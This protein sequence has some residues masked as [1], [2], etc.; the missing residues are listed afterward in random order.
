M[1]SELYTDLPPAI[2]DTL[3]AMM[4]NR[5]VQLNVRDFYAVPTTGR[6]I[7][8]SHL[9]IGSV[10][11]IRDVVFTFVHDKSCILTEV[12]TQQTVLLWRRNVLLDFVRDGDK[13]TLRDKFDFLTYEMT[14]LTETRTGA[15][16]VS[17]TFR[18][19]E[20]RYRDARKYISTRMCELARAWGVSGGV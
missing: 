6:D 11:S 3:S 20:D 16:V 10:V 5:P 7:D 9:E 12:Y 4:R 15:D 19:D 14:H 2:V 1:M 13:L 18:H 17:R 8:P